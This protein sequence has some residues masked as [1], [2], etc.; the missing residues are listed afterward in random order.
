MK[1]ALFIA[2]T[3]YGQKWLEVRGDDGRTWLMS[4]SGKAPDYIVRRKL[5]FLY[6][7][8][9]GVFYEQSEAGVYFS[10]SNSLGVHSLGL[11]KGW[12]GQRLCSVWQPNTNSH[13]HTGAT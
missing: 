10:H 11:Q 8:I 7:T 1:K 5:A 13:S 4:V 9:I 2:V 12:A 6:F 3:V